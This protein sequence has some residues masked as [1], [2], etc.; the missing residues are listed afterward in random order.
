[1]SEGPRVLGS[2][3]KPKESARAREE[4]QVRDVSNAMKHEETADSATEAS[5]LV[6]L[7]YFFAYAQVAAAPPQAGLSSSSCFG[8]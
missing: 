1:M 5:F 2:V 3:N 6:V 8:W 4:L 7:F